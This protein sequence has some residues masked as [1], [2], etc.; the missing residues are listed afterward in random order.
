MAVNQP[1]KSTSSTGR[2]LFFGTNVL[3]AILAVL[4]TVGALNWLAHW[5]DQRKDLSGGL[6]GYR[7]SDRTRQIL[8]NAGN[9]TITTVYTSDDPERNRKDYLPQLRDYCDEIRS[10]TDGVNVRHIYS[11]EER[12]ELRDRV[13]KKFGKAA[14]QYDAVVREARAAWDQLEAQLGPQQQTINGLLAGDSW[15]ASFP[16]LANQASAIKKD[17][18]NIQ[19][20]RKEVDDLVSGEGL[21]RYTEANTKITTAND[22]LKRHLES[23]QTWAKEMDKLAQVLSKPDDEFLTKTIEKNQELV[24]FIARLQQVVGDPKDPNIPD[25]VKPI[26]QEFGRNA[27]VM[28]NWLLEEAARVEAFLK[29]YP[30]LRAHPKWQVQIREAIFV[31]NVPIHVLL[32]DTAEA[33]SQNAQQLRNYLQQDVPKDQ[34]QNIVRQLREFTARWASDLQ[35]W[36]TNSVAVFKEAQSIDPASRQFLAQG[37]SGELFKEPLAKLNDLGTKIKDLPELKMDEVAT[38]LQEDNIVVVE[39]DSEVRVVSFDEVWPVADPM[40]AQMGAG[41]S[42]PQRRVF[43]GDSAISAAVLQMEQE[44]PF[45]T[46]IFVGYESQPPPQMRQFQRPSTGPLPMEGFNTLKEKL[47]RA[48]FVVK[49]WNLGAEADAAKPPEPQ[50]GTEPIYVFLPPA[51]TPPMNPM[52]MQQQPQKSF[53]EKELA[54]VRKV[55]GE[56]ARAIFLALFDGPRP[57]FMPPATYGYDRLLQDEWGVKVATDH[58]VTRAIPS[59][60]EPGHYGIG[61]VQFFYTQLSSFT[62]HVIGKPL[63]A[64]RMYML[65]VCPVVKAEKVP[66]DVTVTPVLEVPDGSADTWAESD[67]MRIINA[68]REGTKDSTFTKSEEAWNPPFSVIVA[69]ENKKTNGKIVVMGTG[70]SFLEDY[71]T[72]RVTRFEGPQ[73]RLV[74]DPPPMENVDLFSNS[75]YWLAAKEELIAAGPAEVPVVTAAVNQ[76][77]QSLWLL[78]MGWAFAMLIAGLGVMMVRRK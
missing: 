77:P 51:E 62:D 61:I 56:G 32:A 48:N 16:M 50:E 25:D 4:F 26:L 29:D 57:P 9:M 15:L 66:E 31:Q 43:D 78:T 45:A 58:R 8:D 38:K 6:T 36:M 3:V 49:E 60:K 10:Y 71:L 69:A 65:N 67:L 12:A 47:K 59:T 42:K 75:L 35:R 63:R 55:L 37:S 33:L 72:R 40:A 11:G 1:P 19:E 64:R 44:K 39:N 14:E 30:A 2:R 5:L 76:N 54:E 74:T 13:G 17:L 53:G 68:L 22:E 41:D 20:T 24:G 46:V 18:V 52:M 34:L 7:L 28:A 21:P 70:A 73:A 23:L 27:G